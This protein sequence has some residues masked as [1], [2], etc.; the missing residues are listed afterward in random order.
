MKKYVCILIL[1]MG[2]VLLAL[3]GR[4]L[5][6]DQDVSWRNISSTED[7]HTNYV[8]VRIYK[9][10]DAGSVGSMDMVKD[11]DFGK[12][13][14]ESGVNAGPLPIM[15]LP[16]PID[17]VEH[18]DE[19]NWLFNS[20]ADDKSSIESEGWGWLSKDVLKRRSDNDL[21]AGAMDAYRDERGWGQDIMPEVFPESYGAQANDPYGDLYDLVGG[22]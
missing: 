6:V 13:G 8:S 4:P 9:S 19:S 3:S 21:K 14:W 16:M 11:V 7:E 17:D 10:S 15:A 1:L 12:T 5:S 2:V 20:A 18:D 22:E